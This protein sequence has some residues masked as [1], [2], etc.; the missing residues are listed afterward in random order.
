MDSTFIYITQL[1][2]ML[3]NDLF[4][5]ISGYQLLGVKFKDIR[6]KLTESQ[7]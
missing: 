3:H 4:N 7:V 6:I 1:E 5:I 2:K